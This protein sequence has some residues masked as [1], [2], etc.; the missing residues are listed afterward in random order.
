MVVGELLVGFKSHRSRLKGAL[1]LEPAIYVG[2]ETSFLPENPAEYRPQRPR[3]WYCGHLQDFHA[4]GILHNYH[5][6]KRLYRP[7]P[8][9]PTA[10]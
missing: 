4:V 1:V 9:I 5:A 10:D 3:H 2:A 6:R 8:G 7:Q